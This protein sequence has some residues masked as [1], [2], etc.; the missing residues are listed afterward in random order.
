MYW[1]SKYAIINKAGSKMAA[2][3]E[4]TTSLEEIAFDDDCEACKL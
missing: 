1:P 4:A 3:N 2:D